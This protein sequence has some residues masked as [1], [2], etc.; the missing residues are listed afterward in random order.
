MR[1]VC[2]LVFVVADE[3]DELD[4]GVLVGSLDG[5]RGPHSFA[6]DFS[7]LVQMCITLL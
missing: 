3:V 6:V 2:A 4:L 5:G 1:C 7:S